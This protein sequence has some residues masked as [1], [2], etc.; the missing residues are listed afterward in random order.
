[1]AKQ[2]LVVDDEKAITSAL[3]GSTRTSRAP[4][5]LRAT[6]RADGV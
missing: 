5:R 1:M 2:L 3:L 6:T 4:G